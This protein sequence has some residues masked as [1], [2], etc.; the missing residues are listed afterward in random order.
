MGAFSGRRIPAHELPEFRVVLDEV[1]RHALLH[2]RVVCGAFKRTERGGA[3]GALTCR[4]SAVT[5]V[6]G[7]D[8]WACLCDLQR[9]LPPV[10]DAR[11]AHAVHADAAAAHLDPHRARQHPHDAVPPHAALAALQVVLRREGVRDLLEVVALPKGEVGRALL[12]LEPDL[13]RSGG[14]RG[15]EPQQAGHAVHRARVRPPFRRFGQP[16]AAIKPSACKTLASKS[17]IF[18]R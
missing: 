12:Q 17:F 5:A 14:H 10:L 18:R 15:E 13:V 7:F 2:G 9:T 11:H 3:H 6:G 8:K 4:G 1:A 16:R